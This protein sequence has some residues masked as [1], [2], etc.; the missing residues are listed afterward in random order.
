MQ[1][2]DYLI[3]GQG[4]AGTAIAYFLWQRKKNFLVIDSPK[5]PTASTVS[6]G[7][8]NPITGRKWLKTWQAEEIFPFLHQFYKDLE[9]HL[10]GQFLFDKQIYRPFRTVSEQN[11]WSVKSAERGWK[12]FVNLE[13]ENNFYSNF[14]Q[15]DLGGWLTKQAA[16]IDIEKVIQSYRKWLKE[17]NLLI[18]NKFDYDSL[19]IK[20]NFVNWKN[21]QAKYI[22]F[23]EGAEGRNNPFFKELPFRPVKG[24]WIKIEANNVENLQNIINTG[25]FILPLPNEKNIFKVGATYEWDNLDDVITTKAKNYLENKLKKTFLKSYKFIE[26]KAGIRPASKD[27]RPI[28][29]KHKEYKTLVIFNGLGTKGVSL[30]PFFAQHLIKHLEDN[31]ALIPEVNIQRFQNN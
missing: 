28:L 11:Q 20:E 25:F 9:K 14:I 16:Y 15:N 19:E 24:E 31:E 23:C 26:Q 2:I 12:N 8:C 18:E 7:V 30:A 17:N 22:I 5:I 10:Q 3:I 29:G 13:L 4:I 1:K 21:I 6:A 27:R